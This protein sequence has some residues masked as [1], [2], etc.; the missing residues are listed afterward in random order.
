MKKAFDWLEKTMNNDFCEW[1]FGYSTKDPVWRDGIDLMQAWNKIH[2]D[3]LVLDLD[4]DMYEDLMK[5]EAL[6][7]GSSIES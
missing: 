1:A 2:G 7:N 4:G 5:M 6:W 3:V